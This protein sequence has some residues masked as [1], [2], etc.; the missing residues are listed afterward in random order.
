MAI[1][2]VQHKFG[3]ND[4]GGTNGSVTGLAAA[5][6]GDLLVG[7]IGVGGGIIS[8]GVTDPGGYTRAIGQDQSTTK[9]C[10]IT[11]KI[12]AG[13]ETSIAWVHASAPWSAEAYEFAG[14]AASAVANDAKGAQSGGV[15]SLASA[16][17]TPS[18]A[19]CV[20]VGAACLGGDDGGAEA[21]DSGWTVLDAVSLTRF[22]PGYKIKTDALT[23]TPTFSWTT[24]RAVAVAIAAFAPLA[25]AVSLPERHYPRGDSRG[26]NRGVA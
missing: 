3:V 2:L 19:N 1:T 22:I 23:E 6:A 14:N 5:T 26:V 8:S 15:T 17:S 25:T 7:I 13:G 9:C 16:A 21:I 10:I 20:Y 12:A 11:A 18:V 24:S 4:A